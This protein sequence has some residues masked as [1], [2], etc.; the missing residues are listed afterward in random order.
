VG[1]NDAKVNTVE[2]EIDSNGNPVY[3]PAVLRARI[4]EK[5][6]WRF[7]GG[8]FAVLF[9]HTPFEYAGFGTGHDSGEVKGPYGVY[10]Y[11]VALVPIMEAEG[12]QKVGKIVLDS[13]CPEII[14]ER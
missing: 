5:V 12:K 4:G 3:R 6:Q 13:G 10:S 2:F 14:I 8:A 11:A 1:K 9:R 7:R